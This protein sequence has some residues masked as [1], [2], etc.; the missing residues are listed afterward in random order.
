MQTRLVDE[1]RRPQAYDWVCKQLDK[2]RQAYVVCPAI[3]ES[4]SISAATAI[5]EAKRL[6]Q[7][8]LRAYTIGVLH[9][10]LKAAER[11]RTMAEFKAG[12]IQVLVATSLIEVGIDV[13]NA[14]VM[15]V[16]GAERFGLAQLHQLRGRVGRGK[17]KS[18][19]LLFSGAEEGPALQRLNALLATV[20]GFALA[21]KDL[22]IRGEGQL[23]GARQAGMNDLKLARLAR[24]RDA[25]ARARA[26]AADILAADPHLKH[27][28]HRPLA[29]AVRA[30]FGGELAW[31]LK[32]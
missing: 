22:E 30:A 2:G 9:G 8:E 10:Q 11:A 14:T 23:F 13:P 1:A 6:R 25:V 19:C 26:I 18:Y 3:Q 24:D 32:A 16:E 4:D 5:A 31:L 21:D 15:I 12:R 7:N 27:A 20:D 29:D 28:E 17:A